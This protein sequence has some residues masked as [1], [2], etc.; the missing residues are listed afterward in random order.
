MKEKIGKTLAQYTQ[1]Y[2]L[3]DL[4][5]LNACINGEHLS[6]FPLEKGVLEI[7]STEDSGLITLTLKYF[8]SRE[9]IVDDKYKSVL[10]KA[11]VDSVKDCCM[12]EMDKEC[13]DYFLSKSERALRE[14]GIY[15]YEVEEDGPDLESLEASS[16]EEAREIAYGAIRRLHG[17]NVGEVQE[18]ETENYWQFLLDK[19]ALFVAVKKKHKKEQ[20]I[21]INK[22]KRQ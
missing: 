22:E 14:W 15:D 18:L 12:G 8:S 16:F 2:P 7:A 10:F 4:F 17:D 13:S 1:G 6:D 11:Q 3:L 5:V 20:T 21:K 9:K 19:Y